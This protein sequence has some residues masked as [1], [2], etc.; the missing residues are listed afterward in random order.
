GSAGN[1]KLTVTAYI[2]QGDPCVPNVDTCAPGLICQ[3]ATP[4]SPTET[5]EKPRCSDG[6]DNDGDGAID[7]PAEPGCTGDADNDETDDCPGGPGCPEC[8]NGSD[9][10]G[11]GATDY[12]ADPGCET[13]SDGSEID[14]CIIGVPVLS[15]DPAGVNGTTSGS[16]T[17]TA[18]CGFPSGPEDV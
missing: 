8:G 2:A 4:S 5:C 3:L 6:L 16:S 12:P 11:D 1:Y 14:D 13:A 17:F 15:L 18:S 10:D 9:D 7:F